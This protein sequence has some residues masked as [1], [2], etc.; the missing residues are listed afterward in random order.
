MYNR[1][2]GSGHLSHFLSDDSCGHPG[3]NPNALPQ[4]LTKSGWHAPKRNTQTRARST[5]ETPVPMVI[6][7]RS[8]A[9]TAKSSLT[10]TP[11]PTFGPP[12]NEPARSRFIGVEIRDIHDFHDSTAIKKA[13]LDLISRGASHEWCKRISISSPRP[14]Q[15]GFIRAIASALL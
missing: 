15:S 10:M 5:S 11:K 14:M 6:P 8:F 7:G 9:D 13:L 2:S 4:H 12:K 3:L 1:R